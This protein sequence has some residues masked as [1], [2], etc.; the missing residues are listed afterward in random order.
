M[1]K[2]G[3][4]DSPNGN[5]RNSNLPQTVVKALLVWASHPI[6]C[7]SNHCGGQGL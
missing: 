5:V 4:L 1:K 7:G 2:S 3:L 6:L